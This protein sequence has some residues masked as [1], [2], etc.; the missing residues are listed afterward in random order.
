MRPLAARLWRYLWAAPASL[1][2]ALVAL[3]AWCAGAQVTTLRGV[4]EVAGGRLGALAART[5]FVAITLGHV[6]LAC[7]DASLARCR[8]HERVHVRQYERF[9]IAFFALYAASSAWQWLRGRDPYRDNAFER[10]ARELA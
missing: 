2:G 8:A 6:V 1:V 7:D 10:E 9:G 5:P 4:V 3:A